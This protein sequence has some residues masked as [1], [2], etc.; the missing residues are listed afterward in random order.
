[1]SDI[2]MGSD[3]FAVALLEKDAEIERLELEV[4]AWRQASDL[5]A[6]EIERLKA[7][8]ERLRNL[9]T[10]AFRSGFLR[11]EVMD[12]WRQSAA[13]EHAGG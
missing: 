5:K 8:N 3:P 2:S 9:L 13:E 1:M 11:K 10:E 4:T 12:A 6:A 7:D